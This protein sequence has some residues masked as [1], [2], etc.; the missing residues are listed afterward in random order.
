MFDVSRLK[1]HTDLDMYHRKSNKFPRTLTGE[2]VYEIEKIIDHDHKF[3]T[4]WYKVAWKGYS[5][6]YESTW[7]PR[8]ELMKGASA[9]VKQYEKENGIS[10]EAPVKRQPKRRR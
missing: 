9:L 3:G 1:P 6:V 8:D 4:Q 10:L 2:D 7:E 5:E